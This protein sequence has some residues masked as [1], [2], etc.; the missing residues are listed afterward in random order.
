VRERLRASN[1]GWSEPRHEVA[2]GKIGTHL[3]VD[4]GRGVHEYKSNYYR[5]EGRNAC[6]GVYLPRQRIR[7]RLQLGRGSQSEVLI[8]TDP[9]CP[10]IG[11]TP[12][13]HTPFIIQSSEEFPAGV[14]D[15]VMGHALRR[16]G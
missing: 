12:P 5:Q 7:P 2:G 3:A 9:Y 6:K 10:A 1:R 4:L 11:K 15:L 13:E 16:G 14:E 8:T